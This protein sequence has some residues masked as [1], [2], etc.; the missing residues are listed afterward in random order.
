MTQLDS[1]TAASL[2]VEFHKGRI[3]ALTWMVRSI[4]FLAI[5]LI[6]LK[7]YFGFS[8]SV[9]SPAFASVTLLA[10]ILYG[11]YWAFVDLISLRVVGITNSHLPRFAS[12][13]LEW[14]E[15]SQGKH[16]LELALVLARAI[17]DASHNR[18]VSY[19]QV[20]QVVRIVGGHAAGLVELDEID[21]RMRHLANQ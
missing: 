13:F 10:A 1:Q 18:P 5:S 21:T 17:E 14:R 2:F 8:V 16:R 11:T 12:L 15:S 3:R 20:A 4:G 7:T 9:Q 6:F 19:R